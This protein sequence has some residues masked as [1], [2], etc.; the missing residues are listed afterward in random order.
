MWQGHLLV[1]ENFKSFKVNHGLMEAG[2]VNHESATLSPTTDTGNKSDANTASVSM[3]A[4]M[5]MSGRLVLGK[6]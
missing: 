3:T 2:Y 6:L 1:L 5:D 4:T